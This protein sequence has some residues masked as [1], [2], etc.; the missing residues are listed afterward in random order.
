M[1]TIHPRLLMDFADVGLIQKARDKNLIEVEP[2]NIR[3]YSELSHARVDDRPFGGGPGMLMRPEPVVSALESLSVF[4]KARRILLSARGKRFDQAAAKRLSSY[5]QLILVCGR[6]EG[7][8]ERVAQ[9]FVDE[10]LSIGDFVLMGGEVAAMVL[11]ESVARL[12]PGV[13][14][15]ESSLVEESFTQ[16]RLSK[17]YAQYTRPQNFRG[18]KV[19]PELLSGNH[20]EIKRWRQYQLDSQL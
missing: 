8:D 5:D 4:G 11:I 9:H 17:E 10:E 2:V 12:L 19:P 18:L 1:L 7:V 14:G 20:R 6:Y 15:N 16:N 13:I 3:K